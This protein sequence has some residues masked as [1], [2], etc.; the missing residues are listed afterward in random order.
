MT[1]KVTR[2]MTN[3]SSG[4]G[5][6]TGDGGTVVQATDKITAV[7]LNKAAG[8]ITTHNAALLAGGAAQFQFNNSF[9]EAGDLLLLTIYRAGIASS[10][11]YNVWGDVGAGAAFITLKNVSGGSLSEAVNINFS[12]IK[13]A[14]A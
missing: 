10:A 12:V 5:Y 2:S 8:R 14:T 9:I 11:N 6:N 3:T 7:T 1:T 4:I 13:G